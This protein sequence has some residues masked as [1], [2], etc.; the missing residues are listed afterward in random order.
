MKKYL[1]TVLLVGVLS[2]SSCKKNKSGDDNYF[3]E[4]IAVQDSLQKLDLRSFSTLVPDLDLRISPNEF[5]RILED[6]T[7]RGVLRKIKDSV[8]WFAKKDT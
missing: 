5:D 7:K 6:Y 1:F 4:I 2:F 3:K 8:G